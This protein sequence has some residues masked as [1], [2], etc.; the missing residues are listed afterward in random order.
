MINLSRRDIGNRRTNVLRIYK[1]IT[2][3]LQQG[4]KIFSELYKQ[5]ARTR[6][7]RLQKHI[8]Q[9]QNYFSHSITGSYFENV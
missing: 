9:I 2:E 5:K 3:S 7:V 6:K 4:L 1:F 8:A